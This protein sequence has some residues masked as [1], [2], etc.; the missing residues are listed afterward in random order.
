MKPQSLYQALIDYQKNWFERLQNPFKESEGIVERFTKLILK[1]E[2]PF[3]RE[4]YPGHLTGSCFV[5]NPGQS[6]ILLLHH[7]KLEKWLQ[8][9]GHCDG[10]I[11]L[12]QV[13]LREAQEESGTKELT[14][15]TSGI[16]DLDIHQIPARKDEPEHLHYDVRYLGI[17]QNPEGIQLA[18]NESTDLAWFSWD[19]AVQ[20]AREPSMHRVFKKIEI[21]KEMS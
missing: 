4:Q 17:C 11:D 12:A 5:L 20:I 3:S 1:T 9:G 16:I 6:E 2:A 8:M 21:L 15:L 14:L 13:A 10:E 19:K 18:E 7:R